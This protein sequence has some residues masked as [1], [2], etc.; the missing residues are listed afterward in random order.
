MSKLFD[1]LAAA[2]DKLPIDGRLEAEYRRGYADGFGVCSNAV[3]GKLGQQ[4]FDFWQGRL[5]DW[6]TA[7][8]NKL[9]LPPEFRAI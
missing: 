2:Y 6:S 9:E 4:L 7:D 5:T 8:C 1:D 3:S